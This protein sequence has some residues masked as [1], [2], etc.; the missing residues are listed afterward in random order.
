MKKRERNA[1]EGKKSEIFSYMFFYSITS[2][3]SIA[4]FL[5]NQ[6]ETLE[7]ERELPWQD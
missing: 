4:C 1:T 2:L 3:S 7:R 6:T 5:N